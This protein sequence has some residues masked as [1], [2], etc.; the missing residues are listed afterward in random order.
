M[1]WNIEYYTNPDGKSPIKDFIDSLPL[2]AK[3]RTVKTL[4]LLESYGI[5]MGEPHV[6]NVARKLW[7]LRVKAKEG[8]FRFFFIVKKNRIII[9][10]H[11][12]QKKSEKTLKR[13]LDIAIKR[14]KEIA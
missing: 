12:F 14:M 7:E 1:K 9:L 2:K 10:L 11:G 3:A 8:I 13:E 5:Q 6:K 4:D